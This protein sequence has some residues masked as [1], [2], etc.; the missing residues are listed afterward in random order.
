MRQLYHGFLRNCVAANMNVTGVDWSGHFLRE[1]GLTEFCKNPVRQNR[2]SR[3]T[4]KVRGRGYYSGIFPIRPLWKSLNA[5]AICS[6]VFMTKGPEP[7]MGSLMG[8]PAI[9]RSV[10]SLVAFIGFALTING[11]STVYD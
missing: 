2:E 4:R 6:R 5:W 7:T 11:D 10:E 9:R 3:A 8:S 1:L